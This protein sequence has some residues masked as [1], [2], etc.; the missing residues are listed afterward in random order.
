VGCPASYE[1]GGRYKAQDV[2]EAEGIVYQCTVYPKSLFCGM[3]G[4]DPPNGLYWDMAWTKLGSCSGSITPT[5]S[6]VIDA[7]ASLGACPDDWEANA[8]YDTGDRVSVDVSATPER[9]VVFECGGYPYDAFCRMHSPLVHG[10]D[11]GWTLVGSCDSGASPS[12]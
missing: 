2:V 5:S 8:P 7:S 4:F 3:S 10:G 6:P 1:D 9:K 12:P 11:L